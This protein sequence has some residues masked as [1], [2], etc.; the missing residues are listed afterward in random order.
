ME[1][2]ALSDERVTA[3]PTALRA[4]SIAG[5]NPPHSSLSV[6]NTATA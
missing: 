4:A 1:A 5:E 2:S 3:M 6:V